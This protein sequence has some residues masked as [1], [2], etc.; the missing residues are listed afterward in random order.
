MSR[1]RF[2]IVVLGLLLAGRP[3]VAAEFFVSP[4]GTDRGNGSEKSPWSLARA[5]SHPGTV[6]PGDTIWLRGG[7]YTGNFTSY[8]KGTAKAPIVVRQYPGERVTLDGNVN[9]AASGSNAPVLTVNGNGGYTWYWGFEVTN[10]SHRC[11]PILFRAS[12]VER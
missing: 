7:T 3:L 8:L 1:Y 12:P 10:S 5:L 6:K 4:T 11:G 9:P 2:S